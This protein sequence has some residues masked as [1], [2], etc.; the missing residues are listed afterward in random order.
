MG[1]KLAL[2]IANSVYDDTN[3]SRLVTP[4][5]DVYALAKV[6]RDQ[7]IGDFDE[8]E[9]PLKDESTRTIM[10]AI[11][12]FFAKKKPDDLLLLYFS[13]HGIL[14]SR[15]SLYLAGRDTDHEL[16][17]ATAVPSTFIN[18]RVVESNSKQK[19]L[20]LDCC[21]S[22]AFARGTKG[23]AGKDVN[24]ANRFNGRGQVV[25]TATDATQYAW[26]GDAVIGE[27]QNSVFT[28]YLVQ[29]LETGEA[30]SNKDGLI[31]LD[32]WYDY[33]QE[34]VTK[35]IP[36]QTPGK[37]ANQQGKLPPIAK[38]SLLP[39]T[40]TE[41]GKSELSELQKILGVQF[42]EEQLLVI[43]QY[44]TIG[45]YVQEQH[46][47]LIRAYMRL[48]EWEG[49]TA[50]GKAFAKIA[51]KADNDVMVP[52][53]RYQ[54]FLDKQII[55]KILYIHNILAQFQD[56]PSPDAIER[57]RNWKAEFYENIDGA[58]ALLQSEQILMRK[59]IIGSVPYESQGG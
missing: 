19:V 48:F 3:L 9:P 11:A 13:G 35:E 14:D 39:P 28:R 59:R 23:Q 36:T 2:L 27:A 17:N 54:P 55:N 20:I 53:R 41:L 37:F 22:G 47:G 46:A 25:L 21:Y 16:I 10:V 8:V 43:S 18:E 5:A 26:E 7:D 58:R 56:N 24:T 30:D 12:R 1:R 34:Q 33:V 6:L 50:T 45:I 38:S 29:G 57:F 52:F 15:G 32:E 44:V 51:L 4:E 49:A 40:P 31:T 42:T